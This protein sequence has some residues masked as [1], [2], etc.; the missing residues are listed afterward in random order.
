MLSR[1]PG[2]K[3]HPVG[4][5]PTS[6]PP[7][8]CWSS[9][10]AAQSDLGGLPGRYDRVGFVIGAGSPGSLPLMA[11]LLDRRHDCFQLAENTGLL[12]SWAAV[13]GGDKCR[14]LPLQPCP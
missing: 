1:Q 6:S 2:W 11:K 5:P 4:T 9:V 13:W 14:P 3:L 7:A 10:T 8:P 12:L